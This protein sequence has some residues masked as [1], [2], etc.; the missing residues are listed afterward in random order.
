MDERRSGIDRRSNWRRATDLYATQH[1]VTQIMN[2]TND[3]I[4]RASEIQIDLDEYMERFKQ[5][6][7]G[8][9]V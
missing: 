9:S 7:H 1:L 2:K 5:P 4:E 6:H 8:Q 3:I